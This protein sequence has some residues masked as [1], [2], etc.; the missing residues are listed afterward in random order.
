M[1]RLRQMLKH[2][3]TKVSP[4]EEVSSRRPVPEEESSPIGAVGTVKTRWW[5]CLLC[6]RR[7]PAAPGTKTEEA[8]EPS[9]KAGRWPRLHLG[10]RDPA[11]TEHQAGLPCS[12]PPRAPSHQELCPDTRPEEA[13]PCTVMEGDPASPGQEVSKPCPSPSLSSS[14]SRGDLESSVE[15]GSNPPYGTTMKVIPYRQGEEVE[16][17]QEGEDLMLLEEEALTDIILHLQGQGK[18]K[19]HGE[20]FLL[21]IP[22]LCRATKQRGEDTL[23]PETCKVV[24]LQKIMDLMETATQDEEPN[25]TLCNSIAAICSLSELEPALE[26]AMESCLL[27]TTLKICLT[28]PK[29]NSLYVRTKQQKHMEDLEALLRSLLATAPSLDRLQFLWEHLTSWLQSP[30]TIDRAKAM[31]SSSA[32][33]RFAVSLLP[34]FEDSPNMPQMG[35]TAAQLCLSLSH[36]AADISCQAREGIYLLAQILLHHKG[37]DMQEAE[38]L[39]HLSREQ[40]SQVQSY[41]DLAQVGEVFQKILSK[42]QRRSFVQRALAGVLD[43]NM[44]VSRAALILLYAMLGEAGYLIG[45]KEEE[46]P[47]RIM[48]KL[49]VMK[50]FKQL[51]REL[52]GHSLLT[53]SSSTPS[54]LQQPKF[55]SAAST[56][57]EADSTSLSKCTIQSLTGSKTAPEGTSSPEPATTLGSSTDVNT[58]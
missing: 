44:C 54:P 10:R 41:M 24:L 21:G 31:R 36:P 27:Q 48:R 29:Q 40:Q 47:A 11:Q 12:S 19:E 23:E 52:Q 30:D 8:E 45:D 2:R 32:L 53:S 5:A 55:P 17:E 57:S 43:I 4:G 26:P 18:D 37:G 49:L 35:D 9:R 3:T 13:A 28:S 56:N 20:R 15:S 25:W 16:E 58:P 6:W 42:G 22:T 14:S 50:G 39:L 33:L 46:I 38:G 7:K 1:D 34:Q 51:P